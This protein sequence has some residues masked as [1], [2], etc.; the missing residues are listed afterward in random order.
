MGHRIQLTG[1]GILVSLLAIMILC[2]AV[3]AFAAAP[4]AVTDTATT[5]EDTAIS[6]YVM[7]NDDLGG[8]QTSISQVSDP[9]N[10]MATINDNNTPAD[11][12]DDYVDYEPDE[13]YHIN[14]G[15][16]VFIYW[17]TN[18][19]GSDYAT[20]EVTVNSVND[21]PVAADDTGSVAEGGTLNVA[22]PGLLNNDT[23]VDGDTL[24]VN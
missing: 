11:P 19:D 7:S 8:K 16:D 9:P 22:A 17:I 24:T 1:R 5:N 10:G 18:E 21:A 13:D 4:D 2:F 12:S 23:D 15:P 20:I 3:P 14:G 6:I